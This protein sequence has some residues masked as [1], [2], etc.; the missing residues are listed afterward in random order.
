MARIGRMEVLPRTRIRLLDTR[1]GHHRL[2]L[3]SGRVRARIWAPPGYFAITA[4]ASETID[5]GCEFEMERDRQGNGSIHVTSGWIMHRVKGQETLVPAGS[6]MAFTAERGE[7][8]LQP[9]RAPSSAL[10]CSNSTRA[11]SQD[12]RLPDIE[13]LVAKPK[14]MA[15]TASPSAQPAD[16]LPRSS[17]QGRSIRNWPRFSEQPVDVGHRAAWSRGGV[18]RNEPLAEADASSSEKPGGSTGGMPLG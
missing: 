8:P 16:A 4:G 17:L 9:L 15:S 3:V 7:S 6:T 12:M 2:E 14:A 13:Q 10:P 11:M 1:T 5:L 18:Q